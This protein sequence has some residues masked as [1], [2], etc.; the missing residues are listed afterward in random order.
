MVLNSIPAIVFYT[1]VDHRFTQANSAFCKFL[2]FP[3]EQVVGKTLTE[4]FP[5]LPAEQLA[6][7]FAVGEEVMSSG[8][9]KRGVIEIMP[10]VRGRRW[11]QND[12]LPYRDGD[13]T[14]LGV[15][16]LG[17]DISDFRE[18]EDKL[19]YL[20]FHD[21][22]TGLYNRTYFE[23]EFRR[24]EK[25]R[26]FPISV[27][28]VNV[29]NLQAVN[30]GAGIMAGND[31]LRRTAKLMRVFRAED[32]TARIGGDLF[33]VI[34]PRSDRSVGEKYR[35]RLR[36]SLD[37]QNKHYRDEPLKLSIGTATG[38]KSQSLFDVLKEAEAAMR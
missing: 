32:V 17:H 20:S 15:I 27:I 37:A 13:G 28:T 35:E 1:D 4:L 5:N 11:I 33:A 25:S 26:Q 7:F 24:L 30:N 6:H 3:R 9:S 16:C 14:L 2:G 31:L 22:L 18:T 21:V 29:V 12:R 38:E 19:L 23:E 36:V 10:S 8:K 34:L